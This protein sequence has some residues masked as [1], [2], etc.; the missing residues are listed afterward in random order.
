MLIIYYEYINLWFII[1]CKYFSLVCHLL[2]SLMLFF[3]VQKLWSF[4]FKSFIFPFIILTYDI[5]YASKILLDYVGI[6]L[7][8]IL[9]LLFLFCT[10]SFLNCTPHQLYNLGQVFGVFISKTGI[11]VATY[12]VAIQFNKSIQVKPL[13]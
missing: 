3:V 11:I 7:H 2:F 5:C 8:F 6:H 13:P 4:I 1:C 10:V 12:Y 9:A